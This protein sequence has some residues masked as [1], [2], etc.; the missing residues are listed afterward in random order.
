LLRTPRRHSLAL[1]RRFVRCVPAL[2]ALTLAGILAAC[3]AADSSPRSPGAATTLA[4][5]ESPLGIAA[6][7]GFVYV[8]G[9]HAGRVWKLDATGAPVASWSGSNAGGSLRQPSGIALDALGNVFVADF[10]AHAVQK[11]DA[12]GGFVTRWGS[13]GSAPGE[14][15]GPFGIAVDG[16]GNVYVTDLDNQRVQK[17]TGD[18]DFVAAWGTKGSAHGQFSDPMGIAV[19]GRGE[20]YVADHGN[21]RVQRFTKDGRFLGAWGSFDAPD[22][23]LLGPVA[24]AAA[25]DG[26]YVTDL[27]TPLLQRFGRDGGFTMQWNDEGG[28]RPLPGSL[29]GVAVDGA[30]VFVADLSRGRLF[31]FVDE[32]A[33]RPAG[34]RPTIFAIGPAWP[35]PSAD[36]AT[37]AF[38][39]PARARLR[40]DVFDVNG[41]HV[42]RLADGPFDPGEHRF[43]WDGRSEAGLSAPAGVYF[44]RGF[45]EGA[46]RAVQTRVAI[47][48]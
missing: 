32:G 42:R 15:S 24:V 16:A 10:G 47:V 9:F 8:A 2:H 1:L 29:L 27:A 4:E 19:D 22:S 35:N 6:R 3:S 18:G 31:S 23:Y 48:R 40:A 28:V 46:G 39:I 25:N 17:F 14:F 41:R 13:R 38:A 37:V 34:R 21:H 12:A 26:L 11:F 45:L 20:V 5:L 44:V 7:D 43:V 36:G 30:Q 33:S